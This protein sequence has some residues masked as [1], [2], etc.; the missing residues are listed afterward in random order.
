MSVRRSV[1]ALTLLL[2]LS[3][4]VASAQTPTPETDDSPFQTVRVDGYAYQ[5]DPFFPCVTFLIER[6]TRLD[7][8]R[9]IVSTVTMQPFHR[10][11][12]GK[13]VA[14]EAY[15]TTENELTATAE[16]GL[17]FTCAP[18]EA[19]DGEDELDG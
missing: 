9:G 11:A 14:D 5:V 12:T 8:E 13:M 15:P 18:Q 16:V 4:A 3:G 1:L 7:G 19:V 6:T 17:A 10:D 2:G